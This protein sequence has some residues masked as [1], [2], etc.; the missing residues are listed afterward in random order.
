MHLVLRTPID[1]GWHYFVVLL[2]NTPF[3]Y[4][5][6]LARLEARQWRRPISLLHQAGYPAASY[7]T[8]HIMEVCFGPPGIGGL[9]P[10]NV[11]CDSCV[12]AMSIAPVAS[13]QWAATLA[14]GGFYQ[15]KGG[16]KAA[17]PAAAPAAEGVPG[18][19]KRKLQALGYPET[20]SPLG[21]VR[22]ARLG[23]RQLGQLVFVSVRPVRKRPGPWPKMTTLTTRLKFQPPHFISW[24]R[25]WAQSPWM[26][27][28]TWRSSCGS[29]R[30]TLLWFHPSIS[31]YHPLS[32]LHPSLGTK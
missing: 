4:L 25:N 18:A 3:W 22:L 7:S 14:M 28:P 27:K 12:R 20:Q 2:N 1:R 11:S 16:G 32:E 6:T 19:L 17:A 8:G 10:Q 30:T 15:G 23:T 9:T 24:Q 26:A 29:K 5:S 21:A 13:A 31:L